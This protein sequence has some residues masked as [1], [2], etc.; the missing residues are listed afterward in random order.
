MWCDLKISPNVHWL[1]VRFRLR[2]LHHCNEH[3]RVENTVPFSL[4]KRYILRHWNWTHN[5]EVV[6]IY[7]LESYF[8]WLDQIWHDKQDDDRETCGMSFIGEIISPWKVWHWLVSFILAYDRI[9]F[10]MSIFA[11]GF[12]LLSHF[13]LS[14]FINL[15]DG[16]IV[17]N[18]VNQLVLWCWNQYSF[19]LWRYRP[20]RIPHDPPW[21]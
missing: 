1:L 5:T 12:Y 9:F 8:P 18:H 3:S 11:E 2:L 7:Y 14:W 21:T 6:I 16:S 15:L 20:N 10:V 13:I 19:S 17:M 4:A